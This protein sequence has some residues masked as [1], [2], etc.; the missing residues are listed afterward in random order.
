[1]VEPW[2]IKR[3]EPGMFY[4]RNPKLLTS[5]VFPKDLAQKVCVEFTC[6]GKDCLREACTFLHPC[7]PKNMTRITVK[8]IAWNFAT[9]KKGWLSDYH[10]CREKLPLDVTAM[11]GGSDG[12]SNSER[13]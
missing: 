13:D 6:K 1:M 8:A 5:D 7:Y 12:P 9:T 4:L 2:S 11:L 10:F 3:K